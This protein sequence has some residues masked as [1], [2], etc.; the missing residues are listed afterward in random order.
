[1]AIGPINF[2]VGDRVRS[3]DWRGD[4]SWMDVRRVDGDYLHGPCFLG[5]G[6]CFASDGTVYAPSCELIEHPQPAREG[7]PVARA[8]RSGPPTCEESAP[9]A[10]SADSVE[11]F[12]SVLWPKAPPAF[13]L[14]QRKEP[15]VRREPCPTCHEGRIFFPDTRQVAD[16]PECAGSGWQEVR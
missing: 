16:C 8:S 11:Y 7:E 12:R 5:D 3:L 4:A 13:S 6:E 15:E 14:G 1:M 9:P 2:K 10:P